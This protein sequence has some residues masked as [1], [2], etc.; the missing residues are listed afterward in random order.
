M[1]AAPV[2]LRFETTDPI[3]E[4]AVRAYGVAVESGLAAERRLELLRHLRALAPAESRLAEA[5]AIALY[6]LGRYADA[7]STLADVPLDSLGADG[8]ATLL[9][10]TLR[11][12]GLPEPLERVRMADLSRPSVFGLVLEASAALPPGAQVRLTEFAVRRLLADDRAAAWLRAVAA[13][14]LPAPERARLA[15][16]ARELD[17]RGEDAP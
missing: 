6:E 1:P 7:R 11:T 10:A 16:L 2:E 15:G 14:E 13:R 12:S 17:A 8:R 4:A 5:E 3:A 9:A